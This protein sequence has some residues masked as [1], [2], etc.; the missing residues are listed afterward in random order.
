MNMVLL[1]TL[2]RPIMLMLPSLL[3]P[4]LLLRSEKKLPVVL[5]PVRVR[6]LSLYLP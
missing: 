2:L 1:L 4:L 5:M 3:P 6:S